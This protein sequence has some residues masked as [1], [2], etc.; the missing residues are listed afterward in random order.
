MQSYSEATFMGVPW[1]PP[2]KPHEIEMLI[3]YTNVMQYDVPAF[4]VCFAVAL[5]H[6]PLLA[7]VYND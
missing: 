5:F 3:E 1:Y 4:F 6:S 2:G 7:I